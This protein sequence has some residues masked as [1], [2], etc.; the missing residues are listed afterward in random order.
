MKIE[1]LELLIRLCN[2]VKIVDG[3]YEMPS[4]VDSVESA[5]ILYECRGHINDVV[6]CVC[7]C[8]DGC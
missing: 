8:G 2:E 7:G 3:K 4:D 1:N 5:R 6:D